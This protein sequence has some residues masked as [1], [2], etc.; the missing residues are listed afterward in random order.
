MR[1]LDAVGTGINQTGDVSVIILDDISEN[2]AIADPFLGAEFAQGCPRADITF[3]VSLGNNLLPLGEVGQLFFQLRTTNLA[4][5]DRHVFFQES[6]I[7]VIQGEHPDI[8]RETIN[9]STHVDGTTDHTHAGA[10]AENRGELFTTITADHTNTTAHKLKRKGAGILEDPELRNI[11]GRIVLHQRTG[12]S[13]DATRNIDLTT[14]CAVGRGVTTITKD[15]QFGAGVQP[16]GIGRGRAF[17][18]DFCS[19]EAERANPLT[20]VFDPE[21]E[22][23]TIFRPQR[24]TN[25][26][27]S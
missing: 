12:T 24:T 21:L 27:M 26:V 8:I 7:A 25:I 1:N 4:Q 20:R 9:R 10:I 18:H 15:S 3:F 2:T 19:F 14:R 5:E 6:L 22:R 16:A 23:T 13:T 17:D 11:I